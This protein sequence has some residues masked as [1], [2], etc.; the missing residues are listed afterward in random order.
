MVFTYNSD[1]CSCFILTYINS[2]TYSHIQNNSADPLNIQKLGS[3][4]KRNLQVGLLVIL[5][6]SIILTSQLC[7][8]TLLLPITFSCNCTSPRIRPCLKWNY[9]KIAWKSE[10]IHA[11]IQVT[12]E[13][14]RY[15]RNE[16]RF[17]KS[18]LVSSYDAMTT[19]T[20][21]LW[22]KTGTYDSQ[23][24]THPPNIPLILNSTH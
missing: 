17:K 14:Y 18:A 24:S 11:V 22:P 16:I 3:S 13:I 12:S 20:L 21:F 23:H 6:T 2:M 1:E 7:Q 19:D 15:I 9:T 4:T 10:K 8:R 5:N